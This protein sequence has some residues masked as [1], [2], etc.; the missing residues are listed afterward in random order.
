MVPSLMFSLVF[1]PTILMAEIQV[2]VDTL[3]RNNLLQVSTMQFSPLKLQSV[4]RDTPVEVFL[5]CTTK[6]DT[7]DIYAM[8]NTYT[9]CSCP[10]G[11][12]V[13]FGSFCAFYQATHG[14]YSLDLSSTLNYNDISQFTKID[15]V[16]TFMGRSI[17]CIPFTEINMGTANVGC[18]VKT[19][20]NNYALLCISS[21]S[22]TITDNCQVMPATF[23]TLHGLRIQWY[24][25]TDG[26]LDFS[27]AVVTRVSSDNLHIHRKS[28]FR[29]LTSTGQ[30]NISHVPKRTTFYSIRGNRLD[31]TRA[32]NLTMRVVFKA[33]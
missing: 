2:G 21:L 7:G 19:R 3:T 31:F 16:H 27:K 26:S 25:Q 24:L 11:S 10:C 5:S 13:G 17:C 1:I 8:I 29:V 18:L 23:V 12:G 33:E 9:T 30:L 22:D 28:T 32:Q 20:T 6:V 14:F 15:T 4:S